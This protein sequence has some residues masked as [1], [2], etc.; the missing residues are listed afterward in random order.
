MGKGLPRNHTFSFVGVSDIE[1]V[2]NGVALETQ[3]NQ[4]GSN[5]S[6]SFFLL[7]ILYQL[8]C[9]LWTSAI[10]LLESNLDGALCCC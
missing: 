6:A 7:D 9:S 10:F 3:K 5:V 8:G 1:P 2:R 4:F